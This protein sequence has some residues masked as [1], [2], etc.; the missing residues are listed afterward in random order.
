[1]ARLKACLPSA[2]LTIESDRSDVARAFASTGIGLTP[3]PSNE[4][5]PSAVHVTA[6]ARQLVAVASQVASSARVQE[7][8]FSEL[9]EL[10][11]AGGGR[12]QQ[13]QYAARQLCLAV[14]LRFAL[15]SRRR[16]T[17]P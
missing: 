17:S 16:K 8:Y 14:P 5:M 1:M 12:R 15:L 10:A 13:V 4:N 9:W 6:L 7:E 3:P 2:G 11:A